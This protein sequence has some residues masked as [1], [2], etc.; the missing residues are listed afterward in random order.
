MHAAVEV[1]SRAY[2]LV[3]VSDGLIRTEGWSTKSA[4][5][6]LAPQ[7]RKW[8]SLWHVRAMLPISWHKKLRAASESARGKCRQGWQKGEDNP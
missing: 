2:Q 5:T 3:E 7:D 4:E 8:R 1:V 6:A